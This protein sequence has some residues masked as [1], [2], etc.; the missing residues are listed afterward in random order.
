MVSLR[1]CFMNTLY[2]DTK[3]TDDIRREHLYNGQLFV[4]SPSAYTLAL[5]ELGRAMAEAAFAPLDPRDA[6]H[7]LS[8]DEYAA[9][10][11]ELK[12]KFIHHPKAKE[13]IQGILY[14]LGCD[15]DK[16][17]FDVPR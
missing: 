1:R 9:I 5:C 4:Y 12:P 6:Q 11:A 15:L 17:Y 10:L 8:V 7:N 16:T 3:F 13:C 2:F 14:E